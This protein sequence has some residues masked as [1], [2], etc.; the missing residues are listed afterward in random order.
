MSQFVE[1]EQ[2]LGFDGGFEEGDP[3]HPPPRPL[4]SKFEEHFCFIFSAFLAPYFCGSLG[5]KWLVTL[6][7]GLVSACG[8]V[9][10]AVLPHKVE[11]RAARHARVAGLVRQVDEIVWKIRQVEAGLFSRF[12][13]HL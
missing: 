4:F 8:R 1:S 5:L 6:G 2:N 7:V 12:G 9:R 11:T 10:V 3:R 13:K